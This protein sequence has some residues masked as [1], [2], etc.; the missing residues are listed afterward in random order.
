[1]SKERKTVQRQDHTD[2]PDSYCCELLEVAVEELGCIQYQAL[3]K[4]YTIVS[5]E[6]YGVLP[7]TYCPFCGADVTSQ[8]ELWNEKYL[9]YV[10]QR[11]C[12]TFEELERHWPIISQGL[13]IEETMR[14]IAEKAAREEGGGEAAD[15]VP[16]GLIQE[17]TEEG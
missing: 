9:E 1:M 8:F 10:S 7:L 16:G 4:E 3:I 6:G 12:L 11:Q 15:V 13:S 2:S 17:E 14:L 5:G